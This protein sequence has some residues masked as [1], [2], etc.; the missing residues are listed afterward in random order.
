MGEPDDIRGYIGKVNSALQI[1]VFDRE[2]S[3]QFV[4]EPFPKKKTH[5]T[6]PRAVQ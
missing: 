5:D 4:L 2:S 1:A 6:P 3:R